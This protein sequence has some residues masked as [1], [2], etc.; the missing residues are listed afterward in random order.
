MGPAKEIS[1][2]RPTLAGLAA[3]ARKCAFMGVATDDQVGEVFNHGIIIIRAA[4]SHF[5]RQCGQVIRPPRGDFVTPD[6]SGR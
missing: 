2:G 3:W 4:G 6:G 1:G 5:P